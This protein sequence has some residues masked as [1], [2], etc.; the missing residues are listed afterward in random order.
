MLG[1]DDSGGLENGILVLTAMVETSKLIK[2]GKMPDLNGKH[3]DI[4]ILAY[5]QLKHNGNY[6]SI[7]MYPYVLQAVEDAY[8]TITSY[9]LLSGK[10][11]PL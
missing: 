7:D 3:M 8:K 2:A 1:N 6:R 11:K 9:Y 10:Q 4:F 5:S